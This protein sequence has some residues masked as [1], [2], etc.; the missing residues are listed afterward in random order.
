MKRVREASA[1]GAATVGTGAAL[2]A[3]VASACCVGPA[4]A[5]IF[6]TVLGAGGLAAV[7]GLRPYTPWMLLA[8]G[9]ALAFSLRLLR[10]RSG[11]DP[12]PAAIPPSVRIA[13]IV[14]W[15]AC[16]VW[17]GSAAYSAYGFLHE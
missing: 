8:S 16:V 1:V 10:R 13:R 15:L 12:A 11:C 17:L 9:A 2:T 14:T 3:G 7:S 5:P 6:V 4:V